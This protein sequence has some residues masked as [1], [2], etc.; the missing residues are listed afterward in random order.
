MAKH[1]E[2]QGKSPYA[3]HAVSSVTF[4]SYS[5]I[6]PYFLCLNFLFSFACGCEVSPWFEVAQKTEM[7]H[8]LV[9]MILYKY[10]L[11]KALEKMG[12]IIYI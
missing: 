5:L 7:F 1:F 3:Y 4:I 10:I 8:C 9:Q 11:L 12:S 2:R 6:T